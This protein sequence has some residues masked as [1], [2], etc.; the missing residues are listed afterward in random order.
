[1]TNGIH[2][3]TAISG[4]ARRNLDFYTRVLGLRLVKKTVNF[5]DPSTY[6]F[7]YG[8]SAGSP[9]TI[10]TFF[11]W[12]HAAPGRLGI[13]ETAETAFQVPSTAIGY[14]THRFVSEGVEHDNPVRRFGETVLPFRDPDGTR[15]ALVST[16]LPDQDEGL[17]SG[18]D[19]PVEHAIRG[20][21]S[22]TLLLKEAG[23]TGA[24]LQD[25]FGLAETGREGSVLRFASGASR[26]GIVQ[27][28]EVGDFLKGRP[29]GG[30]VHHVAFRAA[31]D[32]AERAMVEK[33]ARDHGLATTEQRDRNYFRSVYFREPGGVLFEI[34]TDIP[35]FA[36][37][38]APEELGRALKLPPG[39]EERRAEIEA[40]LP[41]VA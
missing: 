26:G 32:E 35:G 4:L 36:V 19:V 15:L 28:R 23:P 24:I 31:D 38:E 8:D 21:H 9:G 1:M 40:V 39:L 41:K 11:P 17:W 33:L 6:H 37:D 12:E 3:V 30:T 5:D 16:D 29:G 25:V 2:H 22:V 10:L 20:L 14:W 18:A 7:Y 34:A 13:G 27:I